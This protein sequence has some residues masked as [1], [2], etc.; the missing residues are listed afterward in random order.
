[1]LDSGRRVPEVTAVNGVR[2]ILFEYA[3][4]DGGTLEIWPTAVG[5]AEPGSL[6]FGVNGAGPVHVPSA[7]LRQ[8]AAAIRDHLTLLALPDTPSTHTHPGDSGAYEGAGCQ[9]HGPCWRI[10]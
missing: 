3:G 8:L 10:Q 7:R 6:S 2:D 9:L 1:M 5:A 4:P